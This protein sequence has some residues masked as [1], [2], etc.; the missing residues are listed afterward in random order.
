MLESG[1]GR[2]ANIAL[3]SLPGFDQPAD[4]SPAHVLYLDDVLDPGY[5]V[6]R[7]GCIEVSDEPGLGYRV[8]EAKLRSWTLRSHRFEPTRL[9]AA[10]A[11]GG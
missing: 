3:C 10:R 7:D 2:A 9:L 8:D 6:D 11:T 4:M 5:R 1:I